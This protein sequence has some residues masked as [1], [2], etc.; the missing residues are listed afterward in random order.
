M[1]FDYTT[2]LPSQFEDSTR[3]KALISAI[4]AEFNLTNL[5]L[6]YLKNST[7][8]DNALGIWLDEIGD[9]IGVARGAGQVDDSEIFTYCDRAESPGESTLGYSDKDAPAGGYYVGIAGLPDGTVFIDTDYRELIRAKVLSTYSGDTIAEMYAWILSVFEITSYVYTSGPAEVSIE[10]D[11]Y[12]T[13]TQRRIIEALIPRAA[14]VGVSVVSW[15][16]PPI[17]I[18]LFEDDMAYQ[19]VEITEAGSYT[20]DND[21]NFVHTIFYGRGADYVL[22]LADATTFDDRRLFRITNQSPASIITIID[23][24]LE[25]LGILLPL[26]SAQLTL[27]DLTSKAGDWLLNTYVA[28]EGVDER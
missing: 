17:P 24:D 20:I 27:T 11:E 22:N 9:I 13:H 5:I 4:S 12:L 14:G 28:G 16:I 6:A 3:L 1:T 7:T 19:F 21:T 2:R 10:L 8:L 23:G 18:T 26:H 15:P 25:T